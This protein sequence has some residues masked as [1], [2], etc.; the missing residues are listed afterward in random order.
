VAII[1][2]GFIGSE[3]AASIKMKYKDQFNVHLIGFEDHPLQVALG[4][5]VGSAVGLEHERNGVKLH[6]NCGVTELIK[7]KK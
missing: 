3:S 6:M 7:T 1:G 5:D 4:K 2:S